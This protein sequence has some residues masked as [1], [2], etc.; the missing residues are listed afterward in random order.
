MFAVLN[1]YDEKKSF[2]SLFSG[3]RIKSERHSLINNQVFFTVDIKKRHG[4]IPWKKIENCLGILRQDVLLPFD[5]EI[6]HN[7]NINKFQPTKYP[8]IIF[9]SCAV[10]DIKANN[11]IMNR[12]C[13]LDEKGLFLPFVENLIP[14]FSE[15]KIVTPFT[16][17]YE[18]LSHEL[19]NKYGVALL[20]TNQG[21]L[22]G[23]IVISPDSSKV[24]VTF[25]GTLY[26]LNKRHLLSGK[27]LCPKNLIVSPICKE[28]CPEYIDSLIF[29]AALYEKCGI[30]EVLDVEYE[31]FC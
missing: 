21:K 12:L 16:D 13:I 6:P 11:K 28:N 17:E 18:K 29:S 22:N 9:F 19:F 23:D 24:D 15:I 10:K 26:S 20:I 3:D 27:V 5:I 4:K 25:S 30:T 1:F 8:L 7:I 14:L 2:Y 31:R